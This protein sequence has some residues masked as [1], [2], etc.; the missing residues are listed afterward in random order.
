MNNSRPRAPGPQDLD[1][2]IVEQHLET[3][4]RRQLDGPDR[5]R[6]QAIRELRVI[7]NYAVHDPDAAPGTGM[8]AMVARLGL[9]ELERSGEVSPQFSRMLRLVKQSHAG[10]LG[11]EK[12][13]RIRE[14]T[15]PK[16]ITEILMICSSFVVNDSTQDVADRGDVDVLLQ[17]AAT[18]DRDAALQLARLLADRGDLGALHRRTDAGDQFASVQLAR[19]LAERGDIAALTARADMGDRNAAGGLAALLA[20][21]GDIA[22]LTACADVGDRDAAAELAQL[23][24]DRGDLDALH[25]RAVAG[26][27]FAAGHL[28]RARAKLNVI[29]RASEYPAWYPA[30]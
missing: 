8:T 28:G 5:E 13:R 1:V 25:R 4:Q 15:P 27:Q 16:V 3:L 19:R 14:T 12:A 29:A 11:T 26:D 7:L 20:Q 10:S 22:A 30:P 2:S 6:E 9:D 18:G 24:A 23:L 21:R 17:R